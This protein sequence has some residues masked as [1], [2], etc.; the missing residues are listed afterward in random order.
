MLQVRVG[1]LDKHQGEVVNFLLYGL[2]N[3]KGDNSWSSRYKYN[4]RDFR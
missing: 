1:G 3:D 4:T 2:G